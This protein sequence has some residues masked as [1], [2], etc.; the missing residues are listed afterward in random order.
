MY[1]T[2]DLRLFVRTA[3]RGSL[4]A[5]ARD[6]ALQPAT[7][8]ASLKRLEERL[9]ARLFERSTRSLR[10]TQQGELFLDYCRRALALLDEGEG[11]LAAG[12]DSVR[13][14]IRVSAP[15]DLGRGVLRPW[16]DAF[17]DAHP[18]VHL[19]LHLSDRISDLI[20]EPVDLAL[21]YGQPDDSS[22]ISQQLAANR[23]ICVAAPDYLARKGRPQTPH[24]LA[25]HNCL[26]LYL[27][28]G[29]HDNW[30][31]QSP[32]GAAIEVK[33][34]GDRCAD[35]GALVREWA[36]AGMGIAFKAQL[37]VHADL[38]AGRLVTML[39][40]FDGGDYPLHALYPHRN[41][42]PS[43][44]RALIAHLRE[45]FVALTQQP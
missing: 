24:D 4:S 32:E 22:L 34:R 28:R 40:D 18:G 31:F 45:R 12:G 29:L 30:R 14:Q 16:L 41:S 42:V 38:Q 8:S 6:L 44:V 10:L 23:L 27:R 9:Q 25:R 37:D 11:L 17:Q 3:E 15:S 2:L 39:D 20:R 1:S 19:K 26:L 21:R 7:A 5:A 35:D 43:A 36:V 13:G 33:V